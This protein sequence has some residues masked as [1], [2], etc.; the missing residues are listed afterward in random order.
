VLAVLQD[1]VEAASR[2]LLKASS[3]LRSAEDVGAV[4]SA[5]MRFV[6]RVTDGI[7]R[8]LIGCTDLDPQ[9]HGLTTGL[10]P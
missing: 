3:E 8:L 7:D 1:R 9:Q 2:E 4:R 10:R 6:A 5:G